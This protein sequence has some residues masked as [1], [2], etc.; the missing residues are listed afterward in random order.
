M[1]FKY[2]WK[3]TIHSLLATQFVLYLGQSIF[4][5]STLQTNS[6]ATAGLLLTVA[7]DTWK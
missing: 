6:S 2:S 4:I 1:L 3:Y 5:F 7:N